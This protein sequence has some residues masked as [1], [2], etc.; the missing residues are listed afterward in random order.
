MG[1]EGL[2]EEASRWSGRRRVV[3]AKDDIRTIGRRGGGGKWEDKEEQVKG[4]GI[5]RVVRIK[6]EDVGRNGRRED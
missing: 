5:R 3:R 4:S 6:K 2:G 1:R